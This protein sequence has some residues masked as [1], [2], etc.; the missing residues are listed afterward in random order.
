MGVIASAAGLPQIPPALLPESYACRSNSFV[1][2]EIPILK[3]RPNL[4]SVLAPI[5]IRRIA[6]IS[7]NSHPPIEVASIAKH[8]LGSNIPG[9]AGNM[10][11]QRKAHPRRSDGVKKRSWW[12]NGESSF[13]PPS[14]TSTPS[15]VPY[16]THERRS[17][18]NIVE[19]RFLQQAPVMNSALVQPAIGHEMPPNP[20]EN[21]VVRAAI[22]KPVV[23]RR[24]D[25]RH[26]REAIVIGQDT[27]LIQIEEL[28]ETLGGGA[29]M[30]P[31]LHVRTGGKTE[32]CR[33]SRR[34]LALYPSLFYLALAHTMNVIRPN[35]ER[36]HAG[37][38]ASQCNRGDLPALP[39]ATFLANRMA[40]SCASRI[41]RTLAF[42]NNTGE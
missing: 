23:E 37:P 42:G 9:D 26:Q 7:N 25:Q 3:P 18:E 30:L 40:C 8:E 5:R 24:H 13:T 38:I 4:G 1:N 35:G 41:C 2:S 15:L 19:I 21:R 20:L 28:T 11:H 12:P 34:R 16:L 33:Q 6:R 36:G 27:A 29:L 32:C 17:V 14:F 22:P 31:V 10:T 39:D